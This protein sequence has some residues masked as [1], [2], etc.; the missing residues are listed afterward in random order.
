MNLPRKW[1]VALLVAASANLVL[2]AGMERMTRS[3]RQLLAEAIPTVP[4]DYLRMAMKPEEERGRRYA[5]PA[6][7]PPS[8]TEEPLPEVEVS[9]AVE[10][11]APLPHSIALTRI[12]PGLD[13]GGVQLAGA[14]LSG[15]GGGVPGDG[16]HAP[17]EIPF[18]DESALVVLARVA[19][20]F[21][22]EALRRKVEGEV[23]I[24]LTINTSGRAEDLTVVRA[25]PAGLFEQ[26]AMAALLQWRFKP[27]VRNGE[28]TPVRTQINFV[29]R[30][31]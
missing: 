7:P 16:G 14:R 19:P 26:A 5:E 1:P 30:L 2:F 6:P 23:T 18:V 13:I 29:F 24:R 31:D 12:A 15:G 25:D 28:P 22:L 10:A 27:E 21:P 3:E 8:S 11:V 17:V 20:V 4:I 9:A